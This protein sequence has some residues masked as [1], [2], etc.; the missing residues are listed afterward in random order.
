M[1]TQM[2]EG[3]SFRGIRYCVPSLKESVVSR[4]GLCG[5]CRLVAALFLLCVRTIYAVR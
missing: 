1:L 5:L 3:G 2:E 4:G